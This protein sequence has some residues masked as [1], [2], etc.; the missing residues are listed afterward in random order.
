MINL[1]TGK[2]RPLPQ[3]WVESLPE[4]EKLC[5]WRPHVCFIS[6]SYDDFPFPKSVSAYSCCDILLV[7]LIV[8][9]IHNQVWLAEL[10][11]VSRAV[12]VNINPNPGELDNVSE[13]SF[14]KTSS[15]YFHYDIW[16]NIYL[17][18]YDG[19]AKRLR[20]TICYF[21]L[22]INLNNISVIASVK[23]IVLL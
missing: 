19:L 18:I 2:R 14:R 4:D 7:I 22:G 8:G 1:K 5:C 20:S 13:F 15:E 21:T 10:V 16:L 17:I 23:F 12:V 3:S 11:R 6:E 9:V